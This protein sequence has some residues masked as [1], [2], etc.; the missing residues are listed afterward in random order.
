MNYIP[1]TTNANVSFTHK[2]VINTGVLWALT[3]VVIGLI[4]SVT[5]NQN[6]PMMGYALSG[7][8]FIINIIILV[9]AI[10]KYRDDELGGYMTFGQGFLFI[11]FAAIYSGVILGLFTFI[12]MTFIDPGM[13]DEMMNAQMAEMEKQGM[14]EEQMEMANSMTGFMK[15]PIFIAVVTVFSKI[16]G[17]IIMGLIISA[18][19]KKDPPYNTP[20]APMYKNPNEET[21]I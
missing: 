17:G 11:F 13:M 10:K 2:S 5:G 16:I 8:A 20:V 19:F 9:V 15:S 14:T 7:L 12:Q 6:S 21:T 1:Q 18:I 4:P 3:G